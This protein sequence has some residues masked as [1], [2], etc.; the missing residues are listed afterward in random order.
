M[1]STSGCVLF[2]FCGQEGLARPLGWVCDGWVC[3]C[4]IDKLGVRLARST[5]NLWPV[6]HGQRGQHLMSL[7]CSSSSHHPVPT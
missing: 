1:V 4:K 3:S 6:L 7:P 2:G 5:A